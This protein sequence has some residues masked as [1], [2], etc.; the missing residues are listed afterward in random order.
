MMKNFLKIILTFFVLLVLSAPVSAA[1][2]TLNFELGYTGAGDGT[3]GRSG[4]A[5]FNDSRDQTHASIRSLQD[6]Q[7][8]GGLL[9]EGS[10]DN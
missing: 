7:E 8:Y 2:Y 4:E 9:W 10:A 1:S 5:E 3:H 6:T